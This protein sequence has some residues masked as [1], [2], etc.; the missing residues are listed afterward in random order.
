MTASEVVVIDVGSNLALLKC[1]VS[2]GRSSVLLISAVFLSERTRRLIRV[3]I[4]LIVIGVSEPHNALK[5]PGK[6][7]L[8]R[9][10]Q[11]PGVSETFQFR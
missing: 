4:K 1:P 11:M 5:V 8:H 3:G 9:S 10:Y 7:T 2:H 6:F